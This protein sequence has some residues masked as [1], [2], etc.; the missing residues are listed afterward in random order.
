NW[1]KL[2][3]YAKE[4]E[5]NLNNPKKFSK[6]W[7]DKI[8][9]CFYQHTSA[10]HTDLLKILSWFIILVGS[11]ATA[12]FF[13]KDFFNEKIWWSIFWGILSV[14]LCFSI[15]F[16][17]IKFFGFFTLL[18]LVP[19]AWLLTCNPKYIFGVVNLFSHNKCDNN[20]IA[21]CN[22]I[23]CN[24]DLFLNLLLSVYSIFFILLVFSLQKTARKNSII[25]N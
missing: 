12:L 22:I 5:I 4:Q 3:L 25:P 2:E 10:H 19:C 17:K 15:L 9:L 21:F 16:E 8:Q 24:N 11:F 1:H 14:A 20:S 6:D 23:K 18:N 13:E 7:C